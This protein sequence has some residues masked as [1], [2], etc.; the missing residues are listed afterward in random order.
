[1]RQGCRL[2]RSS[3]STG[4]LKV[5]DLVTS[6]SPVFFRCVDFLALLAASNELGE[7]RVPFCWKP[8][9]IPQKDDTFQGEGSWS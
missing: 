3:C 7:S 5:T 6:S 9:R 4:E 2:W 1:M 8:S